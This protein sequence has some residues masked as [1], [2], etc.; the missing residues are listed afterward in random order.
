MRAG[1]QID[2]KMKKLLRYKADG[3]TTVLLLESQDMAL[4]NA[5]K[6]REAV[7]LGIGG[8]L[9]N[10]LDH[11]WYAEDHGETFFDFTAAITDG[12]DQFS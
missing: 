1:K 12:T 9:P 5:H 4:M 11:L 2:R 3:F 7:R 8:R 10:G 6:M